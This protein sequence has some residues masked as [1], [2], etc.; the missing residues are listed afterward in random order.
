LFAKVNSILIRFLFIF[1]K[2]GPVDHITTAMELLLHDEGDDDG[3]DV[4]G[5][6]GE[7]E[8]KTKTKKKKKKKRRNA[9][10]GGGGEELCQR[11]VQQLFVR[12]EQVVLVAVSPP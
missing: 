3:D 12:G 2:K 8:E 10:G 9:T 6:P 11:H 4:D 5:P 1:N 7:E